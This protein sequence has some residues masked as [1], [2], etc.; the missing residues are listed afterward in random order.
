MHCYNERVF[1]AKVAK[2]NENTRPLTDITKGRPA[3]DLFTSDTSSIKTVAD[4]IV[5]QCVKPGRIYAI[6]LHEEC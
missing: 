5:I 6:R 1:S 2:T 4:N 3:Q